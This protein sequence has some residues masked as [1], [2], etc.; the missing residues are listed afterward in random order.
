LNN[1]TRANQ[2][3]NGSVYIGYDNRYQRQHVSPTSHVELL[4]LAHDS[5]TV[6]WAQSTGPKLQTK[7]RGRTPPND[8]RCLFNRLNESAA[9]QARNQKLFRHSYDV[10]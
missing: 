5:Y 3:E 2:R 4:G 6:R 10:V 7:R 8:L 9:E 1:L